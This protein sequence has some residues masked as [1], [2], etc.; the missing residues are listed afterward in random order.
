MWVIEFTPFSSSNS[1][2]PPGFHWSD[3]ELLKFC[4]LLSHLHY[5]SQKHPFRMDFFQKD[6]CI[7]ITATNTFIST[8]CALHCYASVKC[9]TKQSGQPIWPALQW[10][11]ICPLPRVQ[12]T[13]SIH[14]LLQ[15]TGV[16]Q[17]HYSSHYFCIAVAMTAAASILS[18]TLIKALGCWKSNVYEICVQFP[19]SLLNAVPS[20]LAC[21][22]V[23]TQPTQYSDDPIL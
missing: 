9:Y 7:T 1:F 22:N 15:G 11:L 16:I 3:V 4:P 8:V 6:Q 21:T 13:S 20:I 14:Q 18:A 19:P 2:S 12:V 10:C 5:I 17:S 23:S